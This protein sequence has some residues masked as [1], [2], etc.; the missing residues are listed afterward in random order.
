MKEQASRTLRELVS[1]SKTKQTF[2]AI[3]KSSEYGQC[4]LAIQKYFMFF[5]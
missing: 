2:T 5:Q 3:S 4:M 1:Q